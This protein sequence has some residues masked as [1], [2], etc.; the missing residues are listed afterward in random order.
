MKNLY[1]IIIFIL[2][3][4]CV[5]NI[6]EIQKI[7][8]NSYKIT[9]KLHKN[10]YDEIISIVKLSQ[11]KPIFFYVNSLGGTSE[12]LLEAMDAVYE[13][14]NVY[15][16]SVEKCDSACAIMGLATKH[17]YGDFRLHSF[18]SNHHHQIHA[19]PEFNA[20]I[21][22]KLSSYG[23]N[24]DDISYMFDSVDVLWK[25]KIIDNNILYRSKEQK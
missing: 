17:A 13:H 10:E 15:W 18:Y 12:D 21:F 22:K 14:G 4:G 24:I 19:A 6:P 5:T 7:N 23:Y 16:Y 11:G 1:S 8:E 25:V 2:L 3:L 9:G 20:V